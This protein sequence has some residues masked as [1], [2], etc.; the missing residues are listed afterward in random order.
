LEEVAVH[1]AYKVLMDIDDTGKLIN[2]DS[3]GI[4]GQQLGHC[5]IHLNIIITIKLI[6][7]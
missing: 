3:R 1:A 5:Q 7:H 2:G 6:N 4:L